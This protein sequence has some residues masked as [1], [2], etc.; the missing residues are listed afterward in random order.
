MIP[1]E[2][3][4]S[5]VSIPRW[6]REWWKKH[7]SINRSGFFQKCTSII[8]EEKDPEYFEQYR[9]LAEKLIRRNETT[10]MPEK[11]LKITSN[12]QHF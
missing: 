10:P 8:I 11:I 1:E 9:L 7:K 4:F 2:T 12:I 5:I 6:Q 3:T